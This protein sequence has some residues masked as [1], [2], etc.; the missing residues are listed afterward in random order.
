[1]AADVL[2][3][4]LEGLGDLD[5]SNIRGTRIHKVLKEGLMSSDIPAIEQWKI[6][7]RLHLVLTTYKGCLKG[8]T[9]TKEPTDQNAGTEHSIL[10]LPNASETAFKNFRHWLYQKQLTSPNRPQDGTWDRLRLEELVE[11]YTLA[12][13]LRVSTLQNSIADALDNISPSTE[14]FRRAILHVSAN[15]TTDSALLRLLVRMYANNVTSADLR[16]AVADWMGPEFHVEL[17]ALLLEDAAKG[18]GKGRAPK[19]S[20]CEYHIH[21][22]NNPRCS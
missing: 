6:K 11:L 4:K 21:D 10:N 15:P 22:K 16:R 13:F 17:T 12:D 20:A 8:E 3:R 19:A 7:K 14:G 18:K 9:T 1:M 2:L 5:A